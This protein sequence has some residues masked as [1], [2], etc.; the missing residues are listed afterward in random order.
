M[1]W[2]W[3]GSALQQPRCP[4]ILTPSTALA[5]LPLSSAGDA[6]VTSTPA[7]SLRHG[8]SQAG[9]ERPPAAG[10]GGR[11]QAGSGQPPCGARGFPGCGRGQGAAGGCVFDG[12]VPA[13]LEEELA[14]SV[15]VLQL[16]GSQRDSLEVE[17]L[18]AAVP[19]A[20]PMAAAGRQG[21]AAARLGVGLAEVRGWSHGSV[22]PLAVPFE[23]VG[24]LKQPATEF[25][26]SASWQRWSRPVS[27]PRRPSCTFAAGDYPRGTQRPSAAGQQRWLAVVR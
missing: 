4:S 18:P 2:S 26:S 3:A 10:R 8:R 12:G 5:L 24:R 9:A 15:L 27:T 13:G 20:A 23:H 16:R 1:L 22:I 6:T 14:S 17:L 21:P 19:Q 7:P 11:S 25:T